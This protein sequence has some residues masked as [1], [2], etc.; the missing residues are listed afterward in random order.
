[1]VFSRNFLNITMPSCIL[2]FL[3]LFLQYVG[4]LSKLDAAESTYSQWQLPE[5][6]NMRLGKGRIKDIVYSPDGTK[7]AVATSI[8]IWIYSAAKGEELALLIGHEVDVV[9]VAFT[10]DAKNLISVD[11]SGE[12]R[13]WNLATGE[14]FAILTA[15]NVI[16]DK[17]DISS[18]AATLV[19]YNKN[20]KFH[21]WN[22]NKSE[23]ELLVFDD[24]ERDPR[25]LKIS[26]NGNTI[27]T[28]KTPFSSHSE[29][30]PK[31]YRLQVWDTKT[32]SLLINLKGKEPYIHAIEFTPDGKNVI[33]SDIEGDIQFWNGAT[34]TNTFT[35]KA[36]NRGTSA[37]AYASKSEI[38]AI[39]DFEKDILH[40]WS[41]PSNTQKPVI[42]QT[43]KG[44]GSYVRNCV[45]S[46]D[47][48]SIL[49]TSQ[50]GI[51]I[52]WDVATGKQ[53]YN[54]IGHVGRVLE[55]TH[56]DSGN[57]ITSA[58]SE[59]YT[60]FNPVSHLHNW[61]IK[62]GSLKSTDRV[63]LINIETV[64]PNC[65]T[66]VYTKEDNK[67]HL[68]DTETKKKSVTITAGEEYKL[69]KYYIFSS[70]EEL[71][72]IGSTEG[73][74]YMWKITG[75]SKTSEP[76]KSLIT[77]S[78]SARRITFSPDGK[79]LASDDGA[80]TIHLWNIER[81]EIITTFTITSEHGDETSN[82]YR[83]NSRGLAIS[84][85]GKLLASGREDAIYLWDTMTGD[86][87]DVMIPE[88]LS[89]NNMA[90]LF[91]PDN[92][93]LLSACNGTVISYAPGEIIKPDGA[94]VTQSF[95]L[96]GSGTFQLWNTNSGELL[97]TLTGHTDVIDA[98]SFSANGKTLTT[99]SWDGTILLWDWDKIASIR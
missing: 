1:M 26:P 40:L 36:N 89:H 91:S 80:K 65:R 11:A 78:K 62:T 24:T 21:L 31:N 23:T 51:I 34:G 68:W 45:F 12:C 92:N 84:P 88:R 22:L 75:E 73:P 25:I 33:T 67:I 2:I 59:D 30:A 64:S 27:A 46:P 70:N 90:L 87:I 76:W 17:V 53:K 3:T 6:A 55:L 74:I 42:I 29:I 93:I 39:G 82:A 5:G 14:L 60:W 86:E 43:L 63:E 94:N 18:D 81:E 98:F 71:L 38:L 83:N 37:L 13:K 9:T 50:N 47:E 7:F 54:I 85:D 72:A 97:T 61:D 79:L 95:S 49:T 8:G 4:L 44:H 56:T 35:F 99:G 10:Q 20:S 48:K 16:F 15:G 19:K 28:A 41:I 96:F 58:N 77:D 52:A 69:S 66:I 32:Q 57:N